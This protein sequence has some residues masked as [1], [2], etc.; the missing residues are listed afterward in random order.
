M[1]VKKS[2]NES[3]YK[4]KLQQ[5]IHE[6]KLLGKEHT[7]Q[8]KLNESILSSLLAIFLEPKAKKRAE[9]FK[10]TPEYKDLVQ[11]IKIA[12]E[13]LNRLS[14]RLKDKMSEYDSIIEKLQQSGVKVK[15]GDSPDKIY[16]AALK[17]NAAI[18]N[19]YNIR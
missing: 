8:Y 5:I 13:T 19:K 18:L 2:I 12:E 7:K 10:N 3:S 9:T 4:S 14:K 6:S 15:S 17:K 11:Q 16:K 1:Q